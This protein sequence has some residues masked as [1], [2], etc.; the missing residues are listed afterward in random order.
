M[1]RRTEKPLF[2]FIVMINGKNNYFLYDNFDLA[3]KKAVELSIPNKICLIYEIAF[4]NITREF[5]TQK[6][7]TAHDG[8]IDYDKHARTGLHVYFYINAGEWMNPNEEWILLIN[9]RNK[10]EIKER[11]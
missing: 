9:N 7:F 11:E 10:P 2:E 4:N 8:R 6:T 5:Y 1:S 3:L